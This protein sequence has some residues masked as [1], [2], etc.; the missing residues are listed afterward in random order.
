VS[1]LPQA[2]VTKQHPTAPSGPANTSIFFVGNTT[3]IL[4]WQGVRLMAD[5][6][7]LHAGDHVHLGPGVTEARVT[8]PAVRLGELPRIDVVLFSHYRE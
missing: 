1:S 2:K 4:E 8:D 5:P 7:F 6:N 3:T